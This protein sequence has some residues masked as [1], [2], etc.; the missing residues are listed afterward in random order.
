MS[1]EAKIALEAPPPP[2]SSALLAELANIAPVRT[3]R[4][5]LALAVAAALSLAYAAGALL[6]FPTRSDLPFLPRAVY[7]LVGGAWL[8]SFA[9]PLGAA[10]L[11]RR[12]QVVPDGARALRWTVALLAVLVALSVGV[13]MEAPGH[14]PVFPSPFTHFLPCVSITLATSLAP[15]VIALIALRRVVPLGAWRI[16]AA[17]GGAGGALGGLMLHLICPIGGAAHVAVVH[18]GGA[19]LCAALG[20][21][22]GP[23]ILERR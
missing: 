18:V 5:A 8:A 22:A 6:L 10:L 11:P 13:T 7:L 19:A 21:L 3:R 16:G 23:L 14:T 12:R 9:L 4:P 1:D 17:I 2:P 15:F 20:A